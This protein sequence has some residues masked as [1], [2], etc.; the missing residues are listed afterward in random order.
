QGTCEANLRRDRSGVYL[1]CPLEGP[2]SLLSVGGGGRTV[3]PNP[4]AHDRIARIR[5]DRLF[6]LDPAARG[7]YEFSFERPGETAGDLA[8]GPREIRAINVKPVR[9]NVCTGFGI[10]QL[11]IHLD[12]VARP[13]HASFEDIAH[14]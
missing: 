11:H 5:I 12:L 3:P 14:A 4:A 13:P 9:P 1:Q 2:L 8:V 6:L 10:D 7:F